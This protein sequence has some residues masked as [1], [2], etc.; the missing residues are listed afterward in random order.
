MTITTGE[1]GK[2]DSLIDMRLAH[3]IIYLSTHG[4]ANESIVTGGYKTV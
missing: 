4:E 1:K 3:P 2:G